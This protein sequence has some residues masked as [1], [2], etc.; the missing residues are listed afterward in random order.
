MRDNI[1]LEQQLE[2]IWDTYFS[3]IKKINEVKII[4]GRKA[5]T[6]LGSIKSAKDGSSLIQI[7]SHLRNLLI[8]EFVIQSTIAHELVHY[9]H[10]FS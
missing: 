4:F 10:G 6:R 1:W 9:A 2:Q 3:D 7:N 8:P 5:R